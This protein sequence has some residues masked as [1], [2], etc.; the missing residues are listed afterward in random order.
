MISYERYI[1][2]LKDHKQEADFDGMLEN[3]YEQSISFR[4]VQQFKL[5]F[6]LSAIFLIISMGSFL[7][8]SSSFGSDQDISSYV[9]ENNSS[10][11]TI[12]DYVFS[13]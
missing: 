1:A 8:Y 11:N 9:F 5:A 2:S 4:K 10:N 7:K 3:I 6:A 13:K 12:A